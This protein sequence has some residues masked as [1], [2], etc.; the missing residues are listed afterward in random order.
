[1]AN[2]IIRK[3]HNSRFWH[4]LREGRKKT[5]EYTSTQ[6][7]AMDRAESLCKE[8]GGGVVS[9]VLVTSNEEETILQRIEL[10]A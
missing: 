5:L 2:F 8:T 9:V 6:S 10:R 4:I 1:M 7:L 3:E